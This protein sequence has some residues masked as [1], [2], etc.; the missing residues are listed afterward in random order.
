M[1][2]AAWESPPDSAF[3]GP[4]L[5]T[6]G[7]AALA[8]SLVTPYEAPQG[9]LPE[10]CPGRAHPARCYDAGRF[11]ARWGSLDGLAPSLFRHTF[12]PLRWLPMMR[13]LLSRRG[14]DRRT[15]RHGEGTGR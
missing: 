14:R 9:A 7:E 3:S 12:R 11:L 4:A 15:Q 13:Q 10:P 1:T 6:A 5:E 2:R 8:A